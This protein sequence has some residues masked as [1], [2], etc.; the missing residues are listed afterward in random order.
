MD[1]VHK[2]G[3]MVQSMKV[4]GET[5]RQTERVNS[6]MQ[7]VTSTKETGRTTRLTATEFTY[8]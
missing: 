4:S 5:T 3:Q 6:G 8:M 7:M 2:S 1:L